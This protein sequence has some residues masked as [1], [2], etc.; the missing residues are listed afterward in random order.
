VNLSHRESA[1]K[2]TLVLLRAVSHSLGGYKL[3]DILGI[4]LLER[5]RSCT[6]VLLGNVDAV[7]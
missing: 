6:K 7:A 4:R 2:I 3:F 1:I 5:P